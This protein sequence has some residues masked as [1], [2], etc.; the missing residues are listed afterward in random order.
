[1]IL[2]LSSPTFDPEGALILHPSP[3]S[4]LAD[5][6]RRVTR[7][8]TLDGGAAIHDAGYS[9]ADR[10]L[11]IVLVLPSAPTVAALQRL[12]RLYG[13]LT[14]TTPEAV[15]LAVPERLFV[16]AEEATLTLLVLAQLSE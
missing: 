7:T 6:A 16:G 13:R 5:R 10:T 11:T 15:F 14:V 1:M 12:L 8:A 9:V 3:D 4:Q 2:S